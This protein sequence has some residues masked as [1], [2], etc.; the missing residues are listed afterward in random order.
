MSKS[1]YYTSCI[2]T[3]QPTLE[4]NFHIVSSLRQKQTKYKFTIFYF[5]PGNRDRICDWLEN[6]L[7][8]NKTFYFYLTFLI[9]LYFSFSSLGRVQQ[10]LTFWYVRI[11]IGYVEQT[12]LTW[13]IRTHQLYSCH[14]YLQRSTTFGN[15]TWPCIA[16]S[17]SALRKNVPDWLK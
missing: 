16:P 7:H 4:K 2:R 13:R 8:K 17:D 1:L 11:E 9:H 12:P 10:D 14:F 6:K 3:I 15:W 5:L